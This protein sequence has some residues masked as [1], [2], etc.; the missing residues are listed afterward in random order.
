[1]WTIEADPRISVA[2]RIVGSGDTGVVDIDF[3]NTSAEAIG[4][5]EFGL[6]LP[7][8]TCLMIGMAMEEVV[9][10]GATYTW[11]QP[12][13]RLLEIFSELRVDRFDGVMVDAYVAGTFDHFGD[14][15]LPLRGGPLQISEAG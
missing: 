2:A 14:L 8:N 15:Y 5:W 4:L 1:V 13:R 6:L 3:I 10:A 7:D 11:D 9:D 12:L